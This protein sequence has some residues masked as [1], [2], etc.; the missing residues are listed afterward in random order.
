MRSVEFTGGSKAI[1]VEAIM[2]KKNTKT[3]KTHRSR[4]RGT[5]KSILVTA[6]R[7]EFQN[8]TVDISDG[9]QDNIHVMVV[10]RRFEQMGEQA[11]QDLLWRIIDQTNLS[12]A[13][14]SLISLVYPI[15]PSEIK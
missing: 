6:F 11:K 8:D 1:K 9:Y 13:E 2:A 15:C 4:S 3:S 14:K 7:R 12:D 10:S 5:I